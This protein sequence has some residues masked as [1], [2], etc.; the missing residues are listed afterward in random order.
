[1]NKT[2]IFL[3]S[4][5]LI[6]SSCESFLDDQPRGNAI[7]ETTEHYNGLF[8]S[9]QFMNFSVA[10]YS[11]W[12]HPFVKITEQC[13]SDF[14]TTLGMASLNMFSSE[15]AYK[16][17]TDIYEPTENCLAW[18]IA[19]QNIYTYNVIIDGVLDSKDGTLEQK[20]ALHAEARISR[21]WMH[22][23]V[24]QMFSKPYDK[25]YA[26]TELTVPIVTKANTSVEKY[27]RATM[28]ELYDFIEKEMSESCPELEDRPE[29]KMRVYKT[30]G[31][32]LLGKFYWIIGEYAKA[33]EAL[34]TAY[35]RTLNDSENLKLQNHNQL[36]AQFGYREIDLMSLISGQ[37][38]S[39]PNALLPYTYI[40]TE[41]L[42]VKQ[43]MNFGMG[44]FYVALYNNAVTYY[45]DPSLYALYDSNDLR[46]NLIPT[47][48]LMGNPLPYPVGAV[49]D[50]YANYGVEMADIYLA[51]A[52][53][54]ARIGSES[55]AKRLLEEFRKYRV[56]TGFEQVPETVADKDDLIKFCIEEQYREYMVKP[57]SFY[58]IRRLWNDPLFQYMKPF[59]HTL[60]EETFTMQEKDL[61]LQLPETILTWNENWR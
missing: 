10:D 6:L 25:S 18:Q 61:Y 46:R 11:M 55:E 4:F 48:G 36:Q 29:H 33:K 59:T 51:L 60:G 39:D 43:C 47:K 30:T 14:S 19:Y 24:A 2:L 26:E 12:A 1:M 40:S 58:N 57:Q 52:E 22:F 34:S 5:L 45:L 16:Y 20:K 3:L 15:R 9:T 56:R 42:W 31:Y 7:A 44:L 37:S 27:E 41:M 53:C 49:R 54:E 17:E 28:K 23:L 32:A 13:I 50:S 35:T 38:G 21:A 8:N